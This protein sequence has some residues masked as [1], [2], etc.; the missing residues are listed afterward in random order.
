MYFL[1]STMIFV[2]TGA[3]VKSSKN[4]DTNHALD[5]RPIHERV[6]D[7]M[8][9]KKQYLLALKSSVEQEQVD[10]TF[11][12]RIDP[13]SRV[14]A[15]QKLCGYGSN[16]NLPRTPSPQRASQDNIATRAPSNSANPNQQHLTGEQQ[17][18]LVMGFHTDVGSR[19]IDQGRVIAKKKQQLAYERDNELAKAMEQVSICKGS[20]KIVQN[21]DLKE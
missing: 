16:A 14:M 2:D 19:L 8:K 12:P 7:M 13:R 9:Q 17:M 15:E 21:A 11:H 4:N 10:L 3:N 6:A 5:R 20:A 1:A 18:G